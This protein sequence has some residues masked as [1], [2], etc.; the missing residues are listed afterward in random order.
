MPQM[1]SGT[2][3]RSRTPGNQFF[4][5]FEL[6]L[7]KSVILEHFSTI[8]RE[9]KIDLTKKIQNFPK[10]KHISG[11]SSKAQPQAPPEL[12]EIRNLAK[13]SFFRKKRFF[14]NSSSLPFKDPRFQLSEK[15]DPRFLG[16][17]DPRFTLLEPAKDPR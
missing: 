12:G 5:V 14:V 17:K 2:P 1:M 6:V 15:E 16:S 9:K 10:V 7:A 3:N 11:I 8:W 4:Y 13:T